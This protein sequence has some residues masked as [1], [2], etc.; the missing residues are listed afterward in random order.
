MWEYICRP[1]IPANPTQRLLKDRRKL[2][3]THSEVTYN[4]E[5]RDDEARG[6]CAPFARAT[7]PQTA[8][9]VG[10]GVS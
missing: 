2:S 4:A 5:G 3:P 8:S 10:G 1:S 6:G 7:K 9:V